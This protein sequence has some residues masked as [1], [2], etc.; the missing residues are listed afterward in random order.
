MKWCVIGAGGIADRRTIP[1]IIS[2]PNNELIGLMEKAEPLCK[3]LGEKYNVPA[4][5]DAEEML[6]SCDCDA[7]YIGTPVFCHYEQA[8]LALK[9]GKHVF[10]EKPVALD[11]K[12]GKDLVDAFKKAGKLIFVGYMMKY[13]NLHQK[14]RSIIKDGGIGLPNSVRLQFTCWYPK[15]EGAWIWGFIA[16]NLPNTF[17]MK[18]S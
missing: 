10:I 18:K 4:F 5:T 13:H 7:V 3:T 2:N 11:S 12:Q 16:L 6:K 1:A 17:W 8:M 14:A 15:I 9:Y